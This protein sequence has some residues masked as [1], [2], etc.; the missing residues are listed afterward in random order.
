[1]HVSPHGRLGTLVATDIHYAVG[2]ADAVEQYDGDLTIL[3]M[4]GE[5][6]REARRRGLP[7]IVM[8]LIDRAHEDDGS[9]VS[10]R[11]PDAVLHERAGCFR[12]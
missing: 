8:G 6:E 3:T 12:F 10:R 4:A 9:L 11:E 5:L 1:M 2:V 7:V